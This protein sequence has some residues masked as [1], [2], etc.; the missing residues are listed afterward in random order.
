[1]NASKAPGR[2]LPA[3]LI[4][5]LLGCSS[6]DPSG[7]APTVSFVAGYVQNSGHLPLENVQVDLLGDYWT[8]GFPFSVQFFKVVNS[9]CTNHNGYFSFHFDYP[10]NREF[11]VEIHQ[12]YSSNSVPMVPLT[13][14]ETKYVHL[15]SASF[16][17]DSLE[18]GHCH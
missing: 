14:G 16:Y 2:T 17:P 7:P 1:M 11:A 18:I 9:T 12:Q 5:M 13:P 10:D 3:V 6:D 4:L 15:E 8:L